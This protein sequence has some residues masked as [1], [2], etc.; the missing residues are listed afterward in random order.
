MVLR[1]WMQSTLCCVTI[2]MRARY[3]RLM[4]RSRVDILQSMQANLFIGW[5]TKEGAFPS[6]ESLFCYLLFT[7]LGANRNSP[8]GNSTAKNSSK[9]KPKRPRLPK[10]I[11]ESNPTAPSSSLAS[12]SSS[13]S[14]S[15]SS[16]SAIHA[17]YPAQN[18]DNSLRN[19]KYR[20]RRNGL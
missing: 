3:W 9:S 2:L 7:H 18:S 8:P 4:H 1:L 16:S 5:A 15:L 6:K 20:Q 17:V 19:F 11:S 10:S 13:S 12:S 14:S